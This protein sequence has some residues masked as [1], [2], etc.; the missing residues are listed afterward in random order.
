MLLLTWVD[1]INTFLGKTAGWAIVAL[2]FAMCYEVFARYFLRAPTEWAFD[3]SYMLYGALFMLAG[4]YTLA[5]NAHVRGDFLYRAWPPRRQAGIDLVL[6]FLFFFPSIIAFVYVGYKF[7]NMSFVMGERS[8]NWPSGPQLWLFKG[9]IPFVGVFM[10][11][12]GLAEV[13]RCVMCLR[14]GEWPAR[15]HD[16][17]E[18]EKLILEQAEQ[19]GLQKGTV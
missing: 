3:V 16:V 18:T 2:T 11:V 17:E 7:A 14:T 19:Q 12:Q 4:P 10:F 9:L 6:Y 1:R 15:L 5:R 8:M 13:A